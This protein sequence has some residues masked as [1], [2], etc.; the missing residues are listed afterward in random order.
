MVESSETQVQSEVERENRERGT[1]MDREEMREKTM[2]TKL[3]VSFFFFLSPHFL[4]FVH[5]LI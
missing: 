5:E 4:Q 1:Q 2:S 3:V